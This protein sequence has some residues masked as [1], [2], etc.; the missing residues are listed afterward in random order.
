MSEKADALVTHFEALA[1]LKDY[2]THRFKQLLRAKGCRE[3]NDD[4]F[5]LSAANENGFELKTFDRDRD[6]EYH[7]FPLTDLD[8]N[9]EE[10][11]RRETERIEKER[12]D[13]K[14]RDDAYKAQQAYAAEQRDQ[15]EFKRL[16]AKYAKQETVPGNS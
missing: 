5:E 16:T 7:F 10:L 3:W 14:R 8:M 2:F 9:V 12:A 15:A 6:A 1:E 13:A 11:N 4:D